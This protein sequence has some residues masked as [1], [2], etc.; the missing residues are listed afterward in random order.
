M[1]VEDMEIGE[2][3]SEAVDDVLEPSTEA[4][5]Q[6]EPSA[7][8]VDGTEQPD[9][10]SETETEDSDADY[11]PS[12]QEKVFPDSVYERYAKRYKVDPELLSNPQIRQLLNDKIN[13]DIFI[14]QQ[15]AA[16]AKEEET[17]EEPT[18]GAP[19]KQEPN[20]PPEEARKQYM[21]QLD[22]Y[23]NQFVDPDIAKEFDAEFVKAYS[24]E[25]LQPEVRAQM[26]TKTFTKFGLNLLRS[27][28]PSLIEE[29]LMGDNGGQARILDI[30]ERANPQL[31]YQNQWE[32]VRN[33]TE[34]DGTKPYAD[35]PAYH[36]KEFHEWAS[37]AAAKIPDFES[38]EFKGKDGKPLSPREQAAK[39]YRMLV[40]ISNGE[41]VDTS[42]LSKV[43]EKTKENL[44]AQGR[45]RANGQLGAGQSK[46][47]LKPGRDDD[48]VNEILAYNKSQSS[49]IVK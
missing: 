26:I 7:D 10:N 25:S 37:K 19:Q 5:D 49:S 3:T 41:K 13:S 28:A 43:V 39:K 20:L 45:T 8:E 33:T 34:K 30:A 46:G 32:K 24:D 36:T 48:F 11:L 38:L 15:K 44:K 14:T 22:E 29:V 23:A 21:K 4:V 47:Q 18:L 1:S 42:A 35:L 31:M 17:D 9:A 27:V 16:Q 2:P 6:P 40:Q 12:E